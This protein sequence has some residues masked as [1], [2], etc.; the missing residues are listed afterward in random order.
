MYPIMDN[1]FNTEQNRYNDSHNRE[2]AVLGNFLKLF[3]S[4]SMLGRFNGVKP[5]S[6]ILSDMGI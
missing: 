1:C 5:Y 3:P 4:E 2:S 6:L